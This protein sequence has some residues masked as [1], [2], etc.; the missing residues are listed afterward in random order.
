MHKGANTPNAALLL[1]QFRQEVRIR[2]HGSARDINSS[3]ERFAAHRPS[4]SPGGGHGRE[5][6]RHRGWQPGCVTRAVTAPRGRTH[7]LPGRAGGRGRGRKAGRP[8]PAAASVLPYPFAG[9]SYSARS[10]LRPRTDPSP[11]APHR[12]WPSLRVPQRPR[13]RARAGHARPSSSFHPPPA[14]PHRSRGAG[15]EAGPRR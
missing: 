5:K 11:P 3:R 8:Y 1:K 15:G 7:S 6:P 13:P 12:L 9:T 4:P 10:C 2:K 14:S